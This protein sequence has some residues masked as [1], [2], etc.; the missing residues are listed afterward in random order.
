MQFAHS[1]HS[2]QHFTSILNKL[3]AVNARGMSSTAPFY[4]L[5][6]KDIKGDDF[7]FSQLEGKVV[8]VVNVASKVGHYSNSRSS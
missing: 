2:Y 5:S 3:F 7:P 6:A 1:R 8:L 4:A